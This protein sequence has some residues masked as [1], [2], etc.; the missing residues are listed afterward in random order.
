MRYNI[1]QMRQLHKNEFPSLLQE[2]P[3]PP[4][5]LYLEGELPS[6]DWKW[7]TV[8]GSRKFT[9]YG[10]ESC[11]EL[12]M[13]LRGEPVVI[14]SGLAMGID[15]IAHEAALD[16]GLPTVAVP[17]SGLDR[18]VLYPKMNYRLAER[19]LESGGALL[20]EFEPDFRATNWSFPQRNRIMAGL[21]HATL[22]AEASLKSGTMIT[23]KLAREYNR[24]VCAIPGSIF[25]ESSEGPHSLIRDGATPIT[26]AADLK[27]ALG[28]SGLENEATPSTQNLF[29]DCSKDELVIIELLHTPKTRDELIAESG[30]GVS[31]AQTT[32]SVLEIKGLIKESMGEIRLVRD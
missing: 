3:D 22:I 7:L 26:S 8:V 18:S 28:L 31:A 13:G 19:I 6:E 21:A 32:L 20:S 29:K 17:G 30:L 25:S 23:A 4:E 12:I 15:A 24:E 1:T 16:A 9:T 27:E 11:R 14:V 5:K 2:L 10:K